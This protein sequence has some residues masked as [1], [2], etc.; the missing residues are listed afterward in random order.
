[1]PL[2]PDLAWALQH[3]TSIGGARPKSLVESGSHKYIAKFST[4]T[5]LYSVVKA[6]YIAMRLA[7][8]A[9]LNVAPVS[10]LNVA[11]KDVLMVTRFDRISASAG[12][13]RKGIVSALTMLQLCHHRFKLDPPALNSWTHPKLHEGENPSKEPPVIGPPSALNIIH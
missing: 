9:G 4:S 1:V 10:L 6:E 8:K 2:T 7:S 3:G 12:W 11:G 5:D 13:Q